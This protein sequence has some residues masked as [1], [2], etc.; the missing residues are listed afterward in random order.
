M[1][2]LSVS[3][4][5]DIYKAVLNSIPEGTPFSQ[6]LT[7][8]IRKALGLTDDPKHPIIMSNTI[9]ITEVTPEIRMLLQSIVRE[10]IKAALDNKKTPEDDKEIEPIPREQDNIDNEWITQSEIVKMLPNTILIHTR[11]SKVSKAVAA[12][13]LVTNGLRKSECRIQ[14]KSAEAWITEVTK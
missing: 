5:D 11:K 13:K 10:E 8:L 12:G 14:R 7:A 2:K 1:T 9:G 3:I 4:P 6:G